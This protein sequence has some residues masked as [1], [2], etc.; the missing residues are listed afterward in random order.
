M[1]IRVDLEKVY[2]DN[3]QKKGVLRKNNCIINTGD[4]PTRDERKQRIELNK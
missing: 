1:G 4:N 3:M 2:L